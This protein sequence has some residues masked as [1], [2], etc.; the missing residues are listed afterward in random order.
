M[1]QCLPRMTLMKHPVN[2]NTEGIDRVKE[3]CV[4]SILVNE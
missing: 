4:K 2:P 1:F 3:D